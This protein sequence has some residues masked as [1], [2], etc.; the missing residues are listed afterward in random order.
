MTQR[1]TPRVLAILTA[2][3]AVAWLVVRLAGR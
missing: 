3:A 1:D 2:V